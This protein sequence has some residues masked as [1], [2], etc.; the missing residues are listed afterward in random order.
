MREHGTEGRER[1]PGKRFPLLFAAA[2]L[3]AAVLYSIF[4]EVG[5]VNTLKIRATQAQLERENER[6]RLEIAELRKEVEALRSNPSTI[7]EIAR[8]ELGLIGKKEN[9]IVLDRNRNAHAP[10]AE[11]K[12]DRP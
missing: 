11:G 4:G 2:I 1:S 5:I 6:L 12:P 7:E 3:A 9:V 8:K 10:P